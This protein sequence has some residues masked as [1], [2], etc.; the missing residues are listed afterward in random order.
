VK[1]LKKEVEVA[2]KMVRQIQKELIDF[3]LSNVG[4]GKVDSIKLA[5]EVLPLIPSTASCPAKRLGV[6]DLQARKVRD[7]FCH[8]LFP[9]LK[10]IW[11]G[12]GECPCYTLGNKATR[13]RLKEF[14]GEK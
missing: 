10:S 8:V 7:G 2:M 14:I 4:K 1:E 11:G 6:Y 3:E 13:D 9:E 5:K 12:C